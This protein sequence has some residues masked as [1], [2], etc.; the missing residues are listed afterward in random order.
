MKIC[1]SLGSA[2][3]RPDEFA[4]ADAIEV[5]TD[6]FNEIPK[7][8]LREGQRGILTFKTPFDP[9]MIPEGWIVD[10][11]DMKRPDI[12][13]KVLTSYHDFKG[14]PDVNAVV[15]IL[16]GMG[17]DIVKGAF[18]VNSFKDNVTLLEASRSVEK[19]HVILGMGELGRITRI[20]QNKLKNKY[21][22]AYVGTATAP[23]QFS[24]AEM[25][26]F[27]DYCTVT[28]IVGADIG[29]TRS[30]AMHTAAFAHSG[31]NGKYLVFDVLS[32]DRFKEMMIGYDI[33][34]V[35]VTRPYKTDIITH[36][37]QCDKISEDTGAVNTVVNENG[38]LKGYNTDVYGIEMS[39][40]TN[41]VNV[42]GM[43]ALILGTG[44]ASR[45]SAYFLSKS[46]CNA[47]VTGRDIDE[48]RR[49]ASEF[50]VNSKEKA[51]VDVKGYD[52]IVNCIPLIGKDSVSDY[53]IRISEIHSSQIIFDM[54]YGV[55]HLT[56]MAKERNC[57][58]VLGEDMLAHQGS[59]AFELFTSKSVPFKVMRGAI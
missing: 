42:K 25:N 31:I 16:N 28:G 5:R 1:A 48:A 43:R 58:T 21:T 6:I 24:L 20:R 46:G 22:Y 59:K 40:R 29:Y 54:V 37:D 15:N 26:E 3:I 56:E 13:N 14:T 8:I 38:K 11:G 17:G 52:L 7:N 34:G 36:L 9:S 30:P 47:T 55:T 50:G 53:P 27:G 33:K 19:E 18:A 51:S 41:S 2:D 39:L 32:L 44:G 45:S 10:V 57:V 49:I 35:N 23:G 4:S 12:P